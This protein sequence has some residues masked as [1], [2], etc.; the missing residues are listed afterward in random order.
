VRSVERIVELTGGWDRL[1]CRRLKIEVAGFMPLN[2]AV[3]GSGPGGGLLVAVSHTSVQDGVLMRDPEVVAE[4]TPGNPDWLPI[5][6]RQ[7][8][9]GVV[10]EAVVDAHGVLCCPG[11]VADFRKFL[12]LWD[13]NIEAHGFIE[14][15]RRATSLD[16]RSPGQGE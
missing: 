6:F 8:S 7:D 5:S 13:K 9:L 2:I 1:R 12:Q 14:A 16:R 10:Q 11:M 15:A 4:V 3:V